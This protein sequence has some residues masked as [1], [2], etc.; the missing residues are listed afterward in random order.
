MF[1]LMDPP[2]PS[3]SILFI[4][5]LN[6]CW[7]PLFTGSNYIATMTLG[8]AGAHASYYHKA[9]EQVPWSPSLCVTESAGQLAACVWRLWPLALP[10]LQV[11]V[12]FE[13]SSRMQDTS[14]SFGYQ[15]D[16]PKA[17]LL[18]KGRRWKQGHTYSCICFITCQMCSSRI[19][20]DNRI[21]CDLL[22]YFIF[23]HP[24]MTDLGQFLP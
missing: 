9:N 10:Q 17:N 24:N 4:Q 5:W 20:E 8:S 11:G 12:E 3:E 7:P 1:G 14:V 13:A 23:W 21:C 16:V 15:L 2:R 22:N 19:T 6:Q 18:F